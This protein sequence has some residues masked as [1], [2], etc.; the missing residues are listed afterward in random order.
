MCN[1]IHVSITRAVVMCG[2]RESMFGERV[3]VVRENVFGECV[4]REYVCVW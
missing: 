4:V 2:E 1:I 3:C